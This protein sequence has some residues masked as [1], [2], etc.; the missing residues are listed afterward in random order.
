MFLQ[1]VIEAQ[2]QLTKIH[3]DSFED[4]PT[5]NYCCLPLLNNWP[6][7]NELFSAVTRENTK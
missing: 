7:K 3:I 6:E 4:A 1:S 5:H 2:V